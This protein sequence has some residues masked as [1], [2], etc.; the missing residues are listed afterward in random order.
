MVEQDKRHQAARYFQQAYDL[1]MKG[2][3]NEAIQYYKLSI[4]TCPTSEAY[5]FLGW[6]YS[7]LGRLDDAIEQCYKAIQVDP[8]FGNPYNDIGAYLIEKGQLDDAIPWLKRA[9]TARRYT[10]YEYPHLNLG[11]VY[12]QKGDWQQAISAY[13]QALSVNPNYALA[14]RALKRVQAL[15]N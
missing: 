5:T 8:D 13:R 7:F 6:T 10:S 15:L 2:Q 1:Q 14:A 11:R 9:I 12:E 3:L 4:D